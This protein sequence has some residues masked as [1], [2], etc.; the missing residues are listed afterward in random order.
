VIDHVPGSRSFFNIVFFAVLV[1]TVAQGSTFEWVTRQLRLARNRP[2]LPR[3]LSESGTIRSLGTEVLEYT[4]AADDAAVNARVRDLGLPREALV[5]VIVRDERAIPPRGSTRLKPGD[6]L[7][8]LLSDELI[9]QIP[10]LLTRWRKGPVGPLPRPAKPLSGRRPIFSVWTWQTERDGD[11]LDPERIGGSA[12]IEQLRVRRDQP[13]ALWVLEDGRYAVTGRIAAVGSGGDLSD[14]ARRRMRG[15][16]ADDGVW[17][18]E[19]LGAV[20]GDRAESDA[21]SASAATDPE[22]GESGG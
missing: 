9:G 11:M 8:L 15:A 16:P 4:V 6:E 20:A 7:H 17:L 1:S 21:R 18:Q 19:L 2:A 10:G 5:T 12:V 3:P 13:G 14:W 22:T